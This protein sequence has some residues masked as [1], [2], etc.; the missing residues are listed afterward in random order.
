[1]AGKWSHLTYEMLLELAEG[2]G[3]RVLERPLP[4]LLTGLYSDSQRVI[5]IDSR[6][7]ECQQRVA[8]AHEL[9]HAEHHDSACASSPFSKV[10]L[11]TRREVAIRLI[12]LGKYRTAEQ[13]NGYAYGIACDLEVTVQCIRDYQRYLK[14]QEETYIEKINA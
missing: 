11:A 12:D 9:I 8:L 7:I 3:L 14:E 5:L 10:E 2:R 4:D 1:M 6:M 13:V